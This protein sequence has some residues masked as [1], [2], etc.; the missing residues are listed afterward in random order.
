MPLA[1][2]IKRSIDIASDKAC[3]YLWLTCF[4]VRSALLHTSKIGIFSP[5]NDDI[6]LIQTA[7]ELKE[8]LLSTL[9]TRIIPVTE[10]Y[11]DGSIILKF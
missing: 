10:L 7:I 5:T 11:N 2:T 1:L 3:A 9:K 8:F 6:C 4:L